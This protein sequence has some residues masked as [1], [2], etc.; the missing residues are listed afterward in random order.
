MKITAEWTG[1]EWYPLVADSGLKIGKV[2]LLIYCREK[3]DREPICRHGDPNGSPLY[4]TPHL[5]QTYQEQP[6]CD[7]VLLSASL[8]HELEFGVQWE[9]WGSEF[10][11]GVDGALTGI[12]TGYDAVNFDSPVLHARADAARSWV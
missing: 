10:I 12:V 7:E 5:V 9:R 11:H 3:T 2:H 6:G 1:N 4:P 8:R